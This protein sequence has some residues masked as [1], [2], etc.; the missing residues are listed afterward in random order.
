MD[1]GPIVHRANPSRARGPLCTYVAL[2]EEEKASI[3]LYTW[4]T[5]HTLSLSYLARNSSFRGAAYV[6]LL[7]SISHAVYRSLEIESVG[8]GVFV[9]LALRI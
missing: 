5:T 6:R 8:D 7:L 1:G 3:R 9:P 2:K 4:S